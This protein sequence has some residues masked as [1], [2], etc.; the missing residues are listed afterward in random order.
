MTTVSAGA[1][2]SYTF[3]ANEQAT[4]SPTQGEACEVEV[5]R[6]GALIAGRRI[7]TEMSI[8]PFDAGDVMQLTAQRGAVDYTISAYAG[9]HTDTLDSAELTALQTLVSEHG[10]F[11]TTRMVGY[12]LDQPA[13]ITAPCSSM[14]SL[15]AR[16]GSGAWTAIVGSPTLTQGHTGWDGAGVKSG[17]T[18]LTGM[19]DML[20]W[21]PAADTSEAVRLQSVGTNLLT[22]NVGGKFMLVVYIANLPGYQ[23]GG[24][25]AGI[26]DLQVSTG[27]SDTNGLNLSWNTNQLREGWNFLKFVMRD[28]LAYVD[29]SG[30]REYHPYGCTF[31]NNGTGADANIIA[32]AVTRWRI[33][34]RNLNGATLYFD[35]IWTGWSAK[36]QVVLG[37]DGGVGLLEYGVPVL[38]SYGWKGYVALPF[39]VVDSGTSTSTVQTTPESNSLALA[40][41]V[42]AKGWDVVNHTATHPSLGTMSAESDIAYQ[43]GIA[44][45]YW[46]E[47]GYTR[48]SEFYASPQS[49]SSRLAE[50][51]IKT[52]G[53]RLQRH[54]RKWNETVSPWGIAT[55]GFVGAIDIGSASSGVGIGYSDSGGGGVVT[56]WQ[57]YSKIKRAI[58]TAV[59]YQ[60]TL[61]AF[62]HGITTSG[63]AGAGE[64]ATGDDLL[65]TKS[66]FDLSMAYIRQLELAGSLTVCDGISGFYYG[67]NT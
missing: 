48:G 6:A 25:V 45:S 49:S 47:K 65:I 29:S 62:W 59:A 5:R 13:G 38:D 19:P 46:I 7:T 15:V 22:P 11:P 42:Y 56:G 26:I 23:A 31:Q 28:P 21:V 1:S 37:N 16:F 40:A 36:P 4:I 64:S 10:I 57:V 41:A 58:D 60:D 43:V 33:D 32:N 34:T 8:G 18:S 67:T 50:K 14:G 55:P 12:D 51:V 54:A 66:A 53:F 3:A 27:A 20:K 30:V 61:F 35:S 44:K 9:S 39:N 2:G 17:V 52:Q 24:T 63:D